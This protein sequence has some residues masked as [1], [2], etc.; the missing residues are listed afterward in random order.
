MRKF[1]IETYR[2]AQFGDPDAIESKPGSAY[3]SKC[4]RSSLKFQTIMQVHPR[5]P[6]HIL[7]GTF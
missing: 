1:I 5:S 6:R 4:Q 7:S 2:E 3:S